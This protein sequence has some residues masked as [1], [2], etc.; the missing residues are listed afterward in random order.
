MF[1]KKPVQTQPPKLPKQQTPSSTIQAKKPGQNQLVPVSPSLVAN[2]YVVSTIPRPNYE[3]PLIS[4]PSYSSALASPTPR[5]LTPYT[6]D[7]PFGPI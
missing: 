7:E 6:V 3:R 1:G 4:Q 5:A 2:R